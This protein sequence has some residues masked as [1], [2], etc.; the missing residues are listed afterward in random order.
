MSSHAD[1]RE[2]LDP[3]QIEF[4][5]SLDDGQGEALAEIVNEYLSVS[6]ELRAEI[7]RLMGQ[8]DRAALERS[9]HTLK[10]ASANV[11]AMALADA[12]AELETRARES[13][14][15]DAAGLVERIDA[16]SERV[17][18]ALQVVTTRT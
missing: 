14:L 9:T 11:G 8:G 1:L 7:L 4:L 16:E 5:L 15:D 12:C 17:R 10:G 18:A 2:P 13:Q 6:D 3:S